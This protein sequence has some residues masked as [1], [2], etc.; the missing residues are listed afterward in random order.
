M[1]QQKNLILKVRKSM[2]IFYQ[3]QFLITEFIGSINFHKSGLFPAVVFLSFFALGEQK[4]FCANDPVQTNE[5]LLARGYSLSPAPQELNLGNQDIEIDKTWSLLSKID[6]EDI[7]V[8]QIKKG[9]SELGLA[10]SETGKKKII[11][12]VQ[13]GIIK[14][15]DDPALNEQGYFIKITPESVEII[16][17]SKM[18]L[19]YGVQS[20][21]QLLDSHN[22]ERWTLP[23]GEIRDWP[24]L[25]LRF[26][27]WDT[28]HH[29]D[30]ITVLKEYLDKLARLKIN[31]VSFEIWDKFKFPT[32]PDIGVKEGFTPTQLQELVNYG[33]ERYIE[34]VPNIQAPAHMQWLLKHE[35]YAHL[36]AFGTDQQACMCDPEFYK[37]LFSLYKDVIDA[38][39]GV[40][41]FH[42]STDEVYNAGQCKKCPPYNPENRSLAFVNF[43]NKVHDYL[44]KQGRRIIIWGEWPLKPEHIPLLPSDVIEGVLGASYWVGRIQP[45]TEENYITEENNRGIRQLVYTGQ[46]FSLAP[47]VYSE[48]SRGL[49]TGKAKRG[50]PIGAFGAAWDDRGP[51]SE[52][53][54]LG[55]SA[56]AAFSWNNE[57][58]KNVERFV[59]EFMVD[60]YGPEVHGMV[61]IYRDMDKLSNFWNQS[62]DEVVNDVPATGTTRASYGNSAGKWAYNRPLKESTLPSPALPFTP[63]LNVRP[64]YESGKYK[65]LVEEA[66]IMDQLATSVLYRLEANRM[67]AE[68]NFYNLKVLL[69]LTR[70]M[71]HHA[72]LFISMNDMEN[73]LQAA[74]EKAAVGDANGAVEALLFAIRVGKNNINE[75]EKAF[76]NMKDVFAETRVPGHLTREERYFGREPKIG[77]DNW[78]S[79]LSEIL[80]EY[81]RKHEL[82][83]EPIQNILNKSSFAGEAMGE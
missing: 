5:K 20:F 75:R 34:I 6:S 10:L 38:T 39:K 40:N 67:R 79:N 36:R 4:G 33:L 43:V 27:H 35:R 80:L 53:Y 47:K 60:F 25:Q 54:W 49:F 81:A 46:T 1:R 50:N 82:E 37:L 72:R 77:I 52:L 44:S 30:R 59:A 14:G 11:L 78:V 69:T 8:R 62:W 32:D 31:M 55:W 68:G 76:N 12:A 48:S 19:F 28:K 51:H 74:E 23:E 41:Y 83:I 58:P 71:R 63:G 17:N 29:L 21:L 45:I 22:S 3:Q 15:A 42:V 73:N 24:D 9:V 65:D 16:G 64:I 70:Y 61:D 2:F 18:G 13:P 7:A 57:V 66:K 26:I 56:V